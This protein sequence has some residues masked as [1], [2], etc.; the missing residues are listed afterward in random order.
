MLHTHLNAKRNYFFT[1]LACLALITSLLSFSEPKKTGLAGDVLHE[2]NRFRRSNGQPEL[3]MK[4]ELNV[5]AQKHSEDMARGLAVFGHSGFSKRTAQAKKK[6][7]LAG[8]FAENV[9]YGPTTATRVVSMWK[10]SADHRKNM[11]GNYEYMGIGIAKD[12]KGRLY[13]TVLYAG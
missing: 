13:Y 2:T 6:I 11:L 4:E 8:F 7:R 1:P 12:R 9:A 3:I 5:L 10:N